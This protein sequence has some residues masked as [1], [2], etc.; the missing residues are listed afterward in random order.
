MPERNTRSITAAISTTVT[1]SRR[2]IPAF[3]RRISAPLLAGALVAAAIPLSIGSPAVAATS[4][5][6]AGEHDWSTSFEPGE[7][8]A[9]FANR[10]ELD[11]ADNG[12]DGDPLQQNVHGVSGG[13][14]LSSVAQVTASGE[15]APGEAAVWAA[16]S[17]P[18]TKWLVFSATGWLQYRLS[19]AASAVTYTLTSADDAPERDPKNWVLKGSNDGTTWTSLDTQTNQTWSAA[20]RKVKKT[21]TVATPA[22]YSYYRLDGI[23]NHSGGLIQLADW[24]L[25]AS[26]DPNA[27]EAP[28]TTTIG[29]GPT[30]GYNMKARVGW[31]GMHSLRFG[32]EHSGDGAASVTNRLFDVEI[33]VGQ[34][35][36][37]SYMIFPDLTANDLQ[38]PST[39][40]AVNLRFSDGTELSDLAPTDVYGIDATAH[41]QGSGKVLYP[42]QW[43]QVEIDLGTVA[44]GKTI[45]AVQF[46]YD[47]PG[48][49]DATAFG[50]Y[51]DDIA[52]EAEPATV[53]DS[54]LTHFVDTR[55]GT[56]SSS[57]FSRGSN[58]AITSLPNGFNFLVPVTNASATSREYSWQQDNTEANRTRFEGLGISHEPSPWMSDRNLF[59]VMPV[60]GAAAP[61]G[62]WHT[63]AA[64][65]G[66]DNETAQPDYYGVD[67]DNGV[68]AEMT[69]TDHAALMKFTFTGSANSVVLDAP[70]NDGSF[71][72]AADG[73]VTG[74]VENGAAGNT[75]RT[76]MFVSGSF[77]ATP[78]A[79]GTAS[80]GRALTKFA[81]FD[82]S[83]DTT[84][85]L[86]FATSLLSLDQAA[87]NLALEV[88][89]DSFDEI[90]E[91][92]R[93]AWNDRLGVI[94]VEGASETELRTLYSNLYR[95]NLYPNSQF[96]N[97]GTAEAPVYKYASPVSAQV[98][99]STA[100]TTGAKIVDGKMYVNNGFWDTYRTT[101]PAYAM[102]Y[103]ELAGELVDGFTEQY[104]DGGWIARWSSPGYANIMTGTSS[105]VAFA[106]AYLRGVELPD[107][108]ATY[109]AAIKNANTPSAN[110]NV[111]RKSLATSTFLGYT[112][113]S[114]GESVSWAT[115]GYI[116]D[117]GIGN[118]AAALADDPNTPADRVA[119]LRE[120]SEY[121]LDRA[122]AYVNLFDP[123]I[124][125]FQARNADGTFATPAAQYNPKAWWG[126]YTETNGWNFA[127][128]AP[129]DPQGLANLYGGDQGMEDKLD[130]F[131]AT[132]ETSLGS[133]HEEVEAR[134]GRF[135]QWGVSNQVSHHIPFMYNEVGAPAKAQAIVRE[136]LQRS[137]AGGNI[138]QGYAGDEDNG[139]MSAWYIFNALGFYPMQV[140][141]TE[142][143]LGSPLF[144]KATVKLADGKSLVINAPENSTENVY[145]QSLRVNGEEHTSTSIDSRVLTD[146]ATL[147]FTMGSEPSAW[148]T[149]EGDGL[150]SLTTGAEVANPLVDA[151]DPSLAT[152]TSA[153]GE[154]VSA[155]VDNTSRTQVTFADATPAVTVAYKGAKQKP[156]FYTITSGATA[157]ADPSAWTLE[158][159]NDGMTWTEV[160]SRTDREFANRSETV[161]FKIA[162]PAAFQQF[163][164]TV[165]AGDG[166][167]SLS[168]IELLTDG[169]GAEANTLT[170]SPSAGLG[171]TSG[172]A[173]EFDLGI[174]SGGVAEGYAA[175]V[176]WGD[177][178]AVDAATIEAAKLGNHPV[179]AGHTYAEPGVYRATVTAT[180][181]VSS[182]AASV[183]ITVD[184]LEPGS[185]RAAF[186]SVCIGDDGVGAD[187]DAKGFSFPRKGLADGGL[188]AGV[189]HDVPGTD[190]TFTMPVVP[191]G[192]PDNA[193]GAGQTIA[194]DLGE[195]ATKL[196][197]IGAATERNQDTTATVNFTEGD[198]VTIPLQFSDWTKGGNANATAPYGNLEVVKSAYRLAGG[199]V[200]NT[201]SYFFSTV[202]YEIP[203]GR[204][205]ASITMPVQPG[206]PGVEGRVHV[207]AIASNGTQPDLGFEATAGEDITGT[208]GEPLEA[209]LAAITQADAAADAPIVRVQW[210]DGTVTENADVAASDDGLTATGG[211]TYAAAGNYTVSVTVATGA[212]TTH[213]TLTAEI[214]AAPVYETTL[215]A[216]PADDVL[217]GTE[218]A[219]TGDGFKAGESVTVVLQTPTPVESTVDADSDGHV[220]TT[221]TVPADAAPG[222]YAI[223]ATGAESAMP[224]TA[225]VNVVPDETDP[226]YTPQLHSDSTS[227]RPGDLVTVTGEGFAPG[228]KITVEVH[229]DPVV[230]GT[231]TATARGAFSLTF[232]LPDVPVG[233]HR[234]VVTGE[235]SAVP[236]SFAFEVLPA[237]VPGDG[238]SGTGGPT[239][240]SVAALSNTGVDGTLLAIV[241][242]A[243]ALLVL[244]GAALV[245]LRRRA[246]KGAATGA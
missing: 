165:T 141:S 168:E 134:D 176:D 85:E 118:M 7:A 82:T 199:S 220:A 56:N 242:G 234:V 81:T 104:R 227:G 135:G 174:L 69:P 232:T 175:T 210:G 30:S 127:F 17:N 47:N 6:L 172:V 244:I 32:G 79:T 158:G 214:E 133:I 212:R 190:L 162:N 241:G 40:S 93:T 195:G 78:T 60:A 63:R 31:T 151:T 25:I 240:P 65:F 39:Y 178:T 112:P 239:D 171:A 37:L 139:E 36:R 33:P 86:R 75:G 55:R 91:S 159:S 114:Q 16:D 246:V 8:V 106:D 94:E 177:G 12:E 19:S 197:F 121:Y 88:G 217:A 198:P 92:A 169:S 149:G 116:N 18:N 160:D 155:L 1:T 233:A 206:A 145:V 222:L 147:D 221:V 213:L 46:S 181:G 150:P 218:I 202:P 113:A 205:V 179:S 59:S 87:K 215:T 103:P 57:A 237:Q 108:L 74:W 29:T 38:Y 71:T 42:N 110:E 207:F 61:S 157:D 170:F 131:F 101:W 153:G 129:Q 5:A 191:A 73:T 111:G 136:A 140:G 102:L 148:G 137:Y 203:T 45:T 117:Y 180:D 51:V 24:D 186:D 3:L 76:R 229:S 115:E 183:P 66:H 184:Y 123:A 128:H 14:L 189:E 204:T 219:V 167:I 156:T 238:S 84:V 126:P 64:T 54:S 95:L 196:S 224:A 142:L 58:E 130:E 22:A 236:V 4:T 48:G 97:T 21:Y 144:T 99:A 193:T 161:P 27:P 34:R 225:T 83:G 143:V 138:G 2:P 52:I 245:F 124:E 90:R 62:N 100:T 119:Q 96:E 120:E 43:N 216:D 89:G 192:A 67:L 122:T 201:A 243:A 70:N 209:T 105:D 211:H 107:A 154:S 200:Q 53:D 188:T 125:F 10:V 68:T 28:I 41:G 109:D 49:A 166:S 146:G 20:E 231:A 230:V 182:F 208:A 228:E 226:V 23:A 77:D 11:V 26:V 132:P 152:V 35:T 223:V 187:C 164:L 50:G 173:S 194:V 80:G 9:P 163:R 44:A 98:G 15:N 72:I 235:T 185:L 13:S